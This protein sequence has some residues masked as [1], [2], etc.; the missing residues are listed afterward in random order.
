[1]ELN[2]QINVS[3]VKFI[4]AHQDFKRMSD[5]QHSVSSFSRDKVPAK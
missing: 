5:Q 2:Y 3:G 4:F 1:M